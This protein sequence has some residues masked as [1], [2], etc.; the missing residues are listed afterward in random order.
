MEAMHALLQDPRL[1]VTALIVAGLALAAG[2]L[3][4]INKC[5]CLTC[6]HWQHKKLWQVTSGRHKGVWVVHEHYEVTCGNV[7]C[8]ARPR[9]YSVP[10]AAT[11]EEIEGWG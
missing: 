7:T 5:L 11:R 9:R 6:W 4:F 10:R 8:K 2:V 1:T 3:T